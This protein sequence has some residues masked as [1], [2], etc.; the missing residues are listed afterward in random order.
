M[1]S[2]LALKTAA[3]LLLVP[4]V[5][6]SVLVMPVGAQDLNAQITIPELGIDTDIVFAPVVYP[7]WDVSH[8]GSRLGYL[9]QTAWFGQGGNTVLAGHATDTALNP[10][11]LYALGSL[12]QGAVIEVVVGAVALQYAVAGVYR[13]ADTDVSLVLP[14]DYEQLT[15]LT[16]APDSWNGIT[17]TE[18]IIVVALPTVRVALN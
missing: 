3:L 14:T 6:L 5:L 9:E 17:F 15:I 2:S 16:C 7:T 18:R 8:L 13:A 10:D 1:S 4:I 12:E 11:V